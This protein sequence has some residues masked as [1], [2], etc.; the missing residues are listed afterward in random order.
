MSSDEYPNVLVCALSLMDAVLL[1]PH[2]FVELPPKVFFFINYCCMPLK[3]IYIFILSFN[4]YEKVALCKAQ[5][6]IV[7]ALKEVTA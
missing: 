6:D 4:I 3:K 2:R 1:N 7:L 5:L